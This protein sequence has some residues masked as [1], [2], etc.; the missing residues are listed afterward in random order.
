M[1][2]EAGS[3]ILLMAC[4]VL[5]LVWA[6]SPWHDA[7]EALLHATLGVTVGDP[8]RSR[9]PGTPGSTTA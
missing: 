6:N 7:Y 9:S 3:S 1:Q 8:R 2:S 5:A 4:T